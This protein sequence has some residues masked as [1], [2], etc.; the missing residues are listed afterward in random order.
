M[1]DLLTPDGVAL[2]NANNGTIENMMLQVVKIEKVSSGSRF[3]ITMSDG[4]HRMDSILA[5]QKNHLVDQD[6]IKLNAIVHCKEYM[7]NIVKGQTVMI[8]LDAETVQECG[9]LIGNPGPLA[10]GSGTAVAAAAAKVTS[11]G[12]S[13]YSNPYARGPNKPSYGAYGS[14][15]A[16]VARADSGSGN[17]IMIS[18][19]NPYQQK[20]TIK[21]RITN[22]GDMRKWSNAKGEG[23]LFS[24]DILDSSG[25]DIRGTF[26][27]EDATKWFST[28]EVDQVYTFTGGKLKVANPQWNK[29]KSSHE[30]T[31]DRSTSIQHVPEDDTIMQ[32]V[33]DFKKIAHMENIEP[34]TIVDVCGIVIA[35][36]EVGTI[37]SKK[38]GNELTKCELTIV[39][40]SN[41]EITCTVWGDKAKSAR[42]E[43]DGN[44]VVAIK[45]VKVSDFGGRTLSTLNSSSITKFPRVEQ[46]E[47]VKSWFEDQAG[48]AMSSRKKVSNRQSGGRDT[49]ESRRTIS[50]IKDESL[51]Y[52][53]KPDWLSFKA[54]INFIKKDKEGGPWYPA[55]PNPEDPCKNMV[56]V[57]QTS[58]R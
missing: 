41:G 31:F 5:T 47:I 14:S 28:L 23:C 2:I 15:S 43:F 6:H 45:G 55:C 48:A 3:K 19:L 53:E 1:A 46:A 44:P 9:S 21:G 16:P 52:N 36:G 27:K 38:S 35:V 51:G 57:V 11:S 17:I 58:D 39:D 13:G 18:Q 25:T 50:A 8:L 7:V 37:T 42:N 49:F 22:K 40:E 24:I 4:V 54:T 12:P 30:I 26:F 20:W 34:E 29:C 10:A 32:N 33:F 56:K